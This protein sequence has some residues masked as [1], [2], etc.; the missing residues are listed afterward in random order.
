LAVELI[1]ADK[2][3]ISAYSDEERQ[4]RFWEIEG[5]AKVPCGGTHLCRTGEIGGIDLKRRNP[6][7][8]KERIEIRLSQ[9]DSSE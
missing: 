9:D 7:A 4:Q 3:I 1:R 5:F 8:G 2:K 6:G